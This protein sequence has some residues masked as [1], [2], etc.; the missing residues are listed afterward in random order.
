MAGPFLTTAELEAG[1]EHIRQ[2]PKSNGVLELI[3][4]RPEKGERKILDEGLL[5]L[6]KGLVGDNWR[7]RGSTSMPEGSANPETQI[8]VMNARCIALLAQERSRWALAGDQL[9]VDL[10]LSLENLP[11]GTQLA[12]G[13]AIIEITPPPHTGCKK[14][15]SRF[16]LEAMQFVNSPTG[17]QLN[18]RGVNARVRQGGTVKTGDSTVKVSRS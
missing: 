2:S 18:L 13:S 8:T 12:I 4:C 6:E 9:F 15:V 1:L 5:D 7:S 11:P 17:R 14:F 10:D 3:V 16:G